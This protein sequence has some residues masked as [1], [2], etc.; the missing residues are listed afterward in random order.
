MHRCSPLTLSSVGSYIL[1]ALTE[2]H[3]I[4]D[5]YPVR[6][7][8][9][10]SKEMKLAWRPI[11]THVLRKYECLGEKNIFPDMSRLR[12]LSSRSVSTFVYMSGTFFSPHVNKNGEEKEPQTT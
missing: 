8:A 3:N 12:V 5:Y 10:P 6:T 1:N 7:Y 2:I 9:A 11:C 4:D